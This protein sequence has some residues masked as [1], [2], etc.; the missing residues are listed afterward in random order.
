MDFPTPCER[1][2]KSRSCNSIIMIL[3]SNPWRQRIKDQEDARGSSNAPMQY[4]GE[5][6]RF[7]TP[8]ERRGNL[9]EFHLPRL[10][11]NRGC[12][13]EQRRAVKQADALIRAQLL[14]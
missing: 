8:H 5:D 14:G 12:F 4:S 9:S 13:G 6:N 11:M 3:M 2:L 1:T 7:A 10:E